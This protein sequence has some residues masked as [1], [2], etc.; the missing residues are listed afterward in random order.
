MRIA[1]F[2]R[3]ILGTKEH[4]AFSFNLIKNCSYT[5]AFSA[6]AYRSTP[7]KRR[8]LA[9][10]WTCTSGS[11]RPPSMATAQSVSRFGGI[12]SVYFFCTNKQTNKKTNTHILYYIFGRCRFGIGF[13]NQVVFFLFAIIRQALI[14]NSIN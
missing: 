1:N 2:H 9:P 11:R 5:A 13:K 8:P 4:F 7:G 14:C 12:R 10:K 3:L 6:S